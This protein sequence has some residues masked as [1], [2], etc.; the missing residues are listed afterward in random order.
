[1]PALTSDKFKHSDDSGNNSDLP[2]YLNSGHSF[3][4]L[5]HNE[6]PSPRPDGRDPERED[7]GSARSSALAAM[8]NRRPLKAGCGLGHAGEL[9]GL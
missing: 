1:V 5:A 3:R 2:R 9:D 7:S 8:E 4:K 6:V